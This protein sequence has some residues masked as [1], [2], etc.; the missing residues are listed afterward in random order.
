MQNS[1]NRSTEIAAGGVIAVSNRQ[2]WAVVGLLFTASVI[3]YFDRATLSIALPL[4]STELHLDPTAKGVLLSAFFWSY[5]LMQIPMGL[6]ADRLDLRWLYAGAFTLWSVAQGLTGFAS[7]LGMLIVFR[8]ILGVGEAIY[9]PGG[10]RAVSLLFPISERGL[11]C[12]LFDFGTRTGLVLEGL[13]VPWMLKNWG[14]R[15]TFGVIGFTALLWLIPW[16]MFTPKRLRTDSSP[17]KKIAPLSLVTD[18]F[19]LSVGYPKVIGA[20]LAALI[21]AGAGFFLRPSF[22]Q[23]GSPSLVAVL[24]RGA[25]LSEAEQALVPTAQASFNAMVAGALICAVI[26]ILV[27]S[28]L[29]RNNRGAESHSSDREGDLERQTELLKARTRYRNLFGICLGFFCFDYYWYLLVTWLPDYLMTVRKLSLTTAGISM[30]L[31]F[32]VFGVSQPIGGWLADRLVRQGWDETRTRKGIITLSFLTGLLL[33]PAAQATGAGTAV[34]FIIG[35]CLVGLSTPNMLVILQSS[36]PHQE[37]GV[38]VGVY[39]FVGNIA[40]I[41]AP[42]ITGII[43][44]VTGSYTPAFVLAAVM[45]ALG[46]L[47]FWVIV[48]RMGNPE[49]KAA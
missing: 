43:I 21:G 30:T 37:I 16:F 4:I 18:L 1:S 3:N 8:L 38:W 2:R 47:S 9:L 48:G 42:I 45:I 15:V 25:S 39:N 20:C 6:C 5:A 26:G 19:A 14:W 41:L 33:I 49:A 23:G 32:L 22:P 17:E 31:P 24:T 35:G 10:T 44:Q 34:A 40:G 46:Q 11:P 27:G 12:G 29:S 36:A 13:L 28:L 7:S